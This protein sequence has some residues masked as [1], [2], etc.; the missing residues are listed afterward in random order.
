PP[1]RASLKCDPDEA[2]FLR[3]MY[4][5]V[6]SGYHLNKKHWNTVTVNGSLPDDELWRMVDMSYDLVV[7]GLK[8]ADR[9][10]LAGD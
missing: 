8:K 1:L 6:Q 2:L 9:N 3:D 7:K 10:L 4:T 5:A